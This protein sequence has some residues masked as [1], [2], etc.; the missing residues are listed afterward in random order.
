M[1]K[2]IQKLTIK[3]LIVLIVM[4]VWILMIKPEL[5]FLI[6]GLPMV[7]LGEL[8]RLWAAGHL[9]KNDRLIVS[10][11]YAYV[12]NP[13]YIGTFLIATGFC[14][15]GKAWYLLAFSMLVF[16]AYYVPYKKRKES[17]NLRKRF[18]EEFDKYDKAI[19]DYL[20]VLKRYEGAA[21]ESWAF[22]RVR[23]N[24]EHI[25][26]FSVSCGVTYVLLKYAA[27]INPPTFSQV[28]ERVWGK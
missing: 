23:H 22:W 19:P 8:T 28:V 25:T 11:P 15:A 18:G 27:V 26:C 1:M 17:E 4:A 6:A 16:F 20:P 10:G 5:Y 24:E 2:Y 21:P 13:L 9:E 14:V 12:K 7:I 3:L